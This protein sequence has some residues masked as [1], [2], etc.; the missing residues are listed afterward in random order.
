MGKYVIIGGGISGCTAAFE[1]AELGHQVSVVERESV[2]GGK[3]ITY[4]CKATDSCSRCGVCVAHTKFQETVDHPGITLLTGSRVDRYS[5]SSSGTNLVIERKRPS[6]DLNRCTGCRACVDACPEGAISLY[7]RGGVLQLSIDYDKCL[8]HQGKECRIC[9]D[10][11][12]AGALTVDGSSI[13]ETLEADGVLVASGHT[14]YNPAEKPRYGYGRWEHVYTGEE[15]ESFLSDNQYLVKK[16]ARI[17]FIQCVGSR[18][19]EIGRN[20]CSAVCCSYAFRLAKMLKYWNPGSQAVIYYI[21]LQNFDKEFTHF[22]QEALDAGVTLIRGLPFLVE[23]NETGE[24]RLLL[25]GN[26]ESDN[27]GGDVHIYDGV[28]LS[29]GLGP[30]VSASKVSEVFDLTQDEFGFFT[31]S[32]DRTYIC[33]TCS[34]PMTI[35]DS[36]TMARSQALQLEQNRHE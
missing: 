19:P 3:V 24:V 20:Y 25:E 11:C 30:E 12:S 23:E 4:C 34:A 15:A 2:I 8:I 18:D 14:A 17:A 10:T 28:V 33:G 9:A 35:P 31:E 5:P 27:D 13:H 36:M 32:K 6:L 7:D 21:D 29:V 1:L 22:K 26:L 16:D